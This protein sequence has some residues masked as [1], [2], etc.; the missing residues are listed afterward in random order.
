MSEA[1]TDTINWR[2]IGV[3][4]ERS[5]DALI[6]RLIADNKSIFQYLKDLMVFA[7]M[8]GYNSGERREVHGETI[9][10]ILETY[11][12]D[13][14]D[15]FIYLLGLLEHK[16]GHVL[17][18]QNLR[19]CV[20]VFEEYCNSGLYTIERWLDDNP[21]DPSGIET[22]LHHIYLKMVENE[23]AQVP[24]NDDIEIELD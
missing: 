7:A 10:I 15:G 22:L 20:A 8:V 19:K 16:D 6:A 9:E 12:T 23:E 14:K 21:G 3:K 17:K 13:E 18:D 11:A 24:E 4:R 1:Q 2:T 5:H